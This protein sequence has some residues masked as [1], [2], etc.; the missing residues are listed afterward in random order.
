[1][2]EDSTL[3]MTVQE[4]SDEEMAITSHV[5]SEGLEILS[6]MNFNVE[7]G[8]MSI[9]GDTI[10]EDGEII[11]QSYSIFFHEIEGENFI[12]TAVDHNT[13]EMYEVNTIE[14]QASVLP[15]L[16]LGVVLREGAKWAIK[17]YGPRLLISTFSKAAINAAIKKV[18]NFTVSNKHLSNAGG[19]YAKF[20]TT[21][22]TTVNNWIKEG[23]QSSNLSIAVND[24][25]KLSFVI[26]VNLGRKIGTAGETKIKIVIGYDGIIWTSYPV[27]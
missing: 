8:E 26:T 24:N 4:F 27:K 9:T 23:L 5:E 6:N 25:D 15:A 3:E 20:N 19:S 14:A 10:L 12:A 13:G 18:A 1:M 17:K 22:K 21:S 11:T 7:T 16:V 2:G